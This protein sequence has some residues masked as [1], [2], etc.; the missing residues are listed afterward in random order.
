MLM[1]KYLWYTHL[2]FAIPFL[3]LSFFES[4]ILMVS[5]IASALNASFPLPVAVSGIP[6]LMLVQWAP[7]DLFTFALFLK[8]V[9]ANTTTFANTF[10]FD[11]LTAPSTLLTNFTFQQAG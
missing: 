2:F 1:I 7:L 9:G 3:I 8:D 11:P 5:T 6:T 4:R 10:T